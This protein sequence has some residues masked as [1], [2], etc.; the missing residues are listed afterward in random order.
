MEN[1]D[2]KK[3]NLK[4]ARKTIF[5]LESFIENFDIFHGKILELTTSDSRDFHIVNKLWYRTTCRAKETHKFPSFLAI[6][7]TKQERYNK[8]SL[9]RVARYVCQITFFHLFSP[10]LEAHKCVRSR[11]GLTS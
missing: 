4:F 8:F 1:C 9:K 10:Y 3:F 5:E 2:W 6:F 7:M 11:R